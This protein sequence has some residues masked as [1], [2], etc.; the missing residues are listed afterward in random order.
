MLS[1]ILCCTLRHRIIWHS[2]LIKTKVVIL[3]SFVAHWRALEAG[4]RNV[5]SLLGAAKFCCV[6]EITSAL[7]MWLDWQILS[8]IVP[9]QNR[10]VA[11]AD[12][13]EVPTLLSH[14][15]TSR[16]AIQHIST[17]AAKIDWCM[18]FSANGISLRPGEVEM[19]ILQSWRQALLTL[20]PPQSSRG[21]RPN[22]ARDPN[23]SPPK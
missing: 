20:P 11:S 22:L 1:L 18:S 6:V 19:K 14:V 15:L 10:L 5:W 13:P 2:V 8:V 12:R 3:T 16:N 7:A 17:F 21:S 4:R 23:K 9:Y